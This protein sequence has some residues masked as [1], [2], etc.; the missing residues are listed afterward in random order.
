MKSLMLDLAA[1][2]YEA[3]VK[4]AIPKLADSLVARYQQFRQR[5]KAQ[6]SADE[7]E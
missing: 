1:Y 5:R 2:I 4:W 6:D 7:D 3:L